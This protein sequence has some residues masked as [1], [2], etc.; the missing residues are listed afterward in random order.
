MG[1]RWSLH[2]PPFISPDSLLTLPQVA[3]GD[4]HI[5]VRFKNGIHTI[6]LFVD[7]LDTFDL[8]STTLLSILRQRYPN[9]LPKLTT[10]NWDEIQVDEFE[11]GV[12]VNAHDPAR[13]WRK[14][15]ASGNDV[16]AM[17]AGIKD[18]VHVAFRLADEAKANGEFNVEWPT[19]DDGDDEEE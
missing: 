18:G 8:M 4:A 19:L 9:G 5:T 10:K 17:T 6:F 15:E 11:Y 2:Q 1:S 13:G 12:L 7:A 14:I 3:I 16:V